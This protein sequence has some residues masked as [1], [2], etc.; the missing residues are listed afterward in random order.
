MIAS[1]QFNPANLKRAPANAYKISQRLDH[2]AAILGLLAWG[3]AHFPRLT[4]ACRLGR[5]H[6]CA[7][8]DK[9]AN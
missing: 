7:R 9:R 8:L 5:K 1:A 6:W 3:Y 2:P 4:C